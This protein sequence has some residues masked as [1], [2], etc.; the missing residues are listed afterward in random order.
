MYCFYS[1]YPTCALPYTGRSFGMLACPEESCYAGG[2]CAQYYFV[3][4]FHI[5]YFFICFSRYSRA[6]LALV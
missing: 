1:T 5:L 6:T 2:Y 3:V 4:C